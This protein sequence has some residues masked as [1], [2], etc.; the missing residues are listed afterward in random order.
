M[1]CQ[2][3]VRQLN[4]TVNRDLLTR[5]VRTFLLDTNATN[6]RWQAHGLILAI[7]K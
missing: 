1:N 5:F 3:L 6:I 7:Y 2:A 4:K